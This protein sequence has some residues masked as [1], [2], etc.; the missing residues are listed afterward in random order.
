MLA[1][2]GTP[3]DFGVLTIDIDGYDY[4]VLD[5]L[6]AVYRPVLVCA[7]TN[8]KIPP[9]LRFTVLYSDQYSWDVS[10]FYG[11]S[12]SQVGVH[13]ER[14]GYAI[15]ELEYNNVF[16]VRREAALV[17]LSPVEAYER[18]YATRVDRRER[19]PWNQDMEPLQTMDPTDAVGFL[20]ERFRLYAGQ[21]LLET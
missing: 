14:D 21:Y 12:I 9:P 11:Q 10:H 20:Q 13:C 19:F 17:S 16:L 7:E 2:V 4:F 18:G 15:V 1:A 5:A 6:L 3:E 8:E